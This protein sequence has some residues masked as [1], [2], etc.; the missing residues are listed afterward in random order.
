MELSQDRTR[1]VLKHVLKQP[2]VYNKYK[3]SKNLITANGLSSSKIINFTKNNK[4]YEDRKRSR[5]VEFRVVTISKEL[6]QEIIRKDKN[7]GRK[8]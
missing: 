4:T 7:Y 2:G 1:K 5:R 3:W 8:N 6:I